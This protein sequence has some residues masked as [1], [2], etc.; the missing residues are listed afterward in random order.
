MRG[1]V[2]SAF[3]RL[4]CEVK[5]LSGLLPHFLLYFIDLPLVMVDTACVCQ[6][7]DTRKC[8]DTSGSF[9]RTASVM[10]RREKMT[11]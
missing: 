11:G 9:G 3:C 6:D 8:Q 10:E 7:A 5:T 4:S 2:L 1:K